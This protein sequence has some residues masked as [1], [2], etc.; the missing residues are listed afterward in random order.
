MTVTRRDVLRSSVAVLG[1]LSLGCPLRRVPQTAAV[2]PA[3]ALPAGGRAAWANDGG[4]GFARA[5]VTADRQIRTIV[6]L[7]PFRATGFRVETERLDDKLLVHNYGHGGAGITFSWGTSH[8]A[9]EQ[10]LTAASETGLSAGWRDSVDGGAGPAQAGGRACAVLGCGVM[11]LSTAILMQRQGWRVTIYAK[12]VPPHTTSNVAGGLWGPY[13]VSDPGRTTTAY[14][15]QFV[16]AAQLANRYFQEMVGDDYSVRWIENYT[17]SNTPQPRPWF[18]SGIEDLY[19]AARAL[20]ADE[21][22]FPRAHAIA[23]KTLLIEP[24]AYLNALMRDVRIAGGQIVVREFFDLRDVAGL[25]EPLVFNCTG[26]GAKELMDDDE[27][28]PIRGQ[29]TFLVPQPEVDYSVIGGGLYMF[30]RSDGILLG[31]THERGSWSLEPD[32]ETT[33]RILRGHRELFGWDVAGP[34]GPAIVG[35][36][37]R[38]RAD[39]R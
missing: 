30:P 20:G 9:M 28:D 34:G 25:G 33:R 22:P 35:S 26:L 21:Y 7:R 3:P 10:A 17:V 37:P 11:G 8:L 24:H 18:E 32:T 5:K 23:Y 31:G 15:E 14:Y 38:V 12:D 36:S 39:V 1:G 29:L 16:R 19:P 27:M 6:G 4:A 2:A 13:A